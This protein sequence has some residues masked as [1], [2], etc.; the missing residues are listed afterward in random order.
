MDVVRYPLIAPF[1]AILL[2]SLMNGA[3]ATFASAFLTIVLTL[4]PSPSIGKGL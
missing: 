2:C 3:I 1:A 4:A